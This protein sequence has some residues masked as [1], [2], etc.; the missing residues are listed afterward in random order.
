MR[1][2]GRRRRMRV[3]RRRS[4]LHTHSNNPTLKGGEQ[5]TNYCNPQKQNKTKKPK[6]RTDVLSASP[7]LGETAW[8]LAGWL[9]A[10]LAACRRAACFQ[11]QHICPELWFLCFRFTVFFYVPFGALKEF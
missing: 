9:L 3:R 8:L 5:Q 7:N 2:E 4:A 10:M 1:E 11:A 6:L